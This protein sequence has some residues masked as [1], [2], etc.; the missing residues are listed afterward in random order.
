[1]G[2]IAITQAAEEVP[3]RIATLVCLTAFLPQDGQSLPQLVE[4]L[5]DPL[6]APHVQ[7]NESEGTLALILDEL[8]RDAVF[9][10]CD[11]KD[12][13]FAKR[14]LVPESLAAA[15]ASVSITPERAGR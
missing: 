15:D 4:R 14:G 5:L 12:V 11:D 10:E 6:L 1:M 7:V 3:D 8:C 2:G 9:G 13:D